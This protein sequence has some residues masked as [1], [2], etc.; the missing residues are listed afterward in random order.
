[1][2]LMP[3]LLNGFALRGDGEGFVANHGL[4]CIGCGSCS[5][6]CPAKRQLA[7]SIKATIAIEKG[8]MAAK[9]AAEKAKKAAEAAK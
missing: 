4:D 5:Y 6:I 3:I 8:K 7:Q 9:A 2:G 1:M